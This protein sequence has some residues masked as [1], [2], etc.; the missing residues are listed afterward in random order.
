MRPEPSGDVVANSSVLDLAAVEHIAHM[1]GT[2]TWYYTY[3]GTKVRVDK[4]I[5]AVY[6]AIG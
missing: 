5:S 3:I 6:I 4:I 2:S 1:F